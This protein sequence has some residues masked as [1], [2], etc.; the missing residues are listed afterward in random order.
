MTEKFEVIFYGDVINCVRD[1][2]G[3]EYNLQEVITLLNEKEKEIER[4]K[5]II[6]LTTYQLKVQDRILDEL[7]A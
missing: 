7:G 1:E 4:L 6:T 3:K 5:Q 2:N